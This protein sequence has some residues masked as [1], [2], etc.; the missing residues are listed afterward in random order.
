MRHENAPVS[1]SW[2]ESPPSAPYDP[3]QPAPQAKAWRLALKVVGCSPA[4]RHVA[5]KTPLHSLKPL[6]S[7]KWS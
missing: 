2:L 4:R 7:T 3:P 1:Y 5:G 6:R